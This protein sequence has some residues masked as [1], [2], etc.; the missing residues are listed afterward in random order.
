VPSRDLRIARAISA[1]ERRQCV[2]SDAHGGTTNRTDGQ[3][4]GISGPPGVGKSVLLGQYARH[5]VAANKSVAVLAVDPSSPITGGA[6]LADRMRMPTNLVEGHVYIRSL[7][8]RGA[9]G[10]LSSV[11]PAAV[12]LLLGEGFDVVII[13]TVGVGQN[14][15]EI[16]RVADSVLI[17][18]APGGGDDVQGLKAGILEI[19][20]VFVMNKSD[21]PESDR[22]LRTLREIIHYMGASQWVPPVVS[23]V[24]TAGHGISEL[25]D[26]V[27]RHFNWLR[28]SGQLFER[29]RRRVE[30]QLKAAIGGEL[31]L[32]LPVSEMAT[33]VFRGSISIGAALDQLRQHAAKRL[34]DSGPCAL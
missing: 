14:E 1:L 24:G 19:A 2:K 34:L 9:L 10:G 30:S 16:I 29:R 28:D 33:Q 32:D 7:A 22:A 11:V 31:Q 17:V 18:Q 26:A 21:L 12:D 8:S 23:T 15:T 13:E 5:L 4:V 25:A 6:I 27:T 20:D 3:V